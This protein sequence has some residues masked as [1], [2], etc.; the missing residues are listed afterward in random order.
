MVYWILSQADTQITVD[1]LQKWKLSQLAASPQSVFNQDC[2]NYEGKMVVT[3]WNREI[4]DNNDYLLLIKHESKSECG[5]SDYFTERL[6]P[7][8]M[9][10]AGLG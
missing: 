10:L 3:T 9:C 5:E 7:C 8:A 4:Y 2:G 1:I 6:G